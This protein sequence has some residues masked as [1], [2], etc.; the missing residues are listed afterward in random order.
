MVTP[1]LTKGA[2]GEMREE[3]RKF[4]IQVINAILISIVAV[5]TTRLLYGS[6]DQGLEKMIPVAITIILD[7]DEKS[8]F[9]EAVF[10][11]SQGNTKPLNQ[12]LDHLQKE[13]KNG[14]LPV[15]VPP[16]ERNDLIWVDGKDILLPKSK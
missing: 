7:Q 8:G 4:I 14:I 12:W 11:N 13:K 16:I 6:T 10:Q 9:K 3:T 2:K 1:T 15:V 5:T